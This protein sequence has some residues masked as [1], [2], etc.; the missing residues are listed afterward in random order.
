MIH[1]SG[2]RNR[3]LPLPVKHWQPIPHDP[4]DPSLE[5]ASSGAGP[6]PYENVIEPVLTQV[7]PQNA[8]IQ[9]IVFWY[10]AET[11]PE[12][13]EK[14]VNTAVKKKETEMYPKPYI[15]PPHFPKDITLRQ[16]VEMDTVGEM[17]Y[18]PK[19]H[20][21]TGVDEDEAGYESYL[22]PVSEAL[23]LLAKNSKS[24]AEVVR[25]GWAL[26]QAR[27]RREEL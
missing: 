25:S 2:Y 12:K 9:Y 19:R 10:V 14:E 5:G 18:E 7:Y 24:L 6:S 17:I 21:G 27:H 22:V 1:K 8:Q 23:E 15:Q 3:L 11:L 26:I 16:R 20:E 4:V 13:V